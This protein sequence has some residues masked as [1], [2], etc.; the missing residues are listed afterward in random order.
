MTLH[1]GKRWTFGLCASLGLA[2][3][4][5][6]WAAAPSV[7]QALKLAPVQG[8]RDVSFDVP[9]ANAVANCTIKAE[10]IGEQTGWV[11]RSAEGQILRRFVDTNDDNVVDQWSYFKDGI[12]VYR[13]IDTDFDT[14]AD[15]F[16]WLNT[17]GSRWGLDNDKDGKIDAWKSISPEEVS[18]EV[19]AA[20]ATADVD[21]FARLL[22]LPDELAALGLDDAK[23]QEIEAK[24]SAAKT[25]FNKLAKEQNSVTEKTE[26]VDFA[27]AAPG[28]V[29]AG[30]E[31]VSQDLLVYENVLAMIETGEK[32][33]QVA[34]GTLIRA[35]ELW[36]II[37]APQAGDAADTTAGVFFK[38]P[39]ANRADLAQ[40][41]SGDGVQK[42]LE[43]LEQLDKQAAEAS[44]EEAPAFNAKR[45]GFM[46]QIAA[47][48]NT[49]EEKTNWLKQ[50]VDTIGVA[51]QTAAYPEGI[52]ELKKILGE[53]EAQAALAPLKGYVT[54]RI[55]SAEYNVAL[56]QPGAQF[57]KIQAKWIEDLEGFVKDFPSEPDSTPEALLQLGMNGEYGGDDNTATKWY[58]KLARDF[59]ESTSAK[60]AHGAIARLESVGK[61]LPLKGRGMDGKPVD[62][63]AKEY[64]GRL[65]LIHYWATWCAPCV[66]EMAELKELQAKFGGKGFALIGV[67][68]DSRGEDAA[69]FVKNKK[70]SW[71]QIFEPGGLD[72]RPANELGI[73]SVPTMIL[74]DQTGK[75][76]NRNIH[77]TEL[78]RELAARLRDGGDGPQQQPAA[79]A[80]KRK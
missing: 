70:L 74:V 13:D 49:P 47:A 37:D 73:L 4:S 69:A 40:A 45:I 71:A 32:H 38:A 61:P 39:Q 65:V 75:V 18:S 54:F 41:G 46:R 16:R 1:F 72:S 33:G 5:P 42:L 20:L 25:Q 80:A 79:R 68:L 10:K 23:R 31:G 60:K 11:V 77:V 26:W 12:E 64:K 35:G 14:K 7:E 51:V 30:T 50:A 53:V 21:R 8:S 58:K 27:A 57:E 36:R 22:L 55:I 2:A 66:T 52:E 15:Q 59:A 76:V 43:Q 17:G 24:L 3:A 63:S 44:P 78:E 19:V 34:V 56:Q 9:D 28:I 6:A 67:N 62:L 29:P 48:V